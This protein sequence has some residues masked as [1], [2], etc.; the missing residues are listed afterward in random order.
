MNTDEKEKLNSLAENVIG[1]A[2]EVS[3]QLGAGFLEKVYRNALHEELRRRDVQVECEKPLKVRY[4]GVVVGD[5]A[6]DL[7]V[8]ETLVIELK[9][10]DS[11]A[12]EH[13]AQ[14]L[15]YLKATNLALGLILNFQRPR[16]EIKR[17]ANDF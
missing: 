12:S 14:C 7:L 2:F 6:A 8:A 15:N 9:C 13:L 5:Y 17:V 10:V 1:A 11:I 3:N 4:K 16:V